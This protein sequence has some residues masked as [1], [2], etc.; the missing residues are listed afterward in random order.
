MSSWE[1]ILELFPPEQQLK[2]I[3]KEEYYIPVYA[4]NTFAANYKDTRCIFALFV[5]SAIWSKGIGSV[6]WFTLD[7]EELLPRKFQFLVHHLDKVEDFDFVL[8]TAH[9]HR[10]QIKWDIR[11]D[12]WKYLNN[13][14]V[15]FQSPSTSEAEETKPSI[16]GGFKKE[17]SDSKGSDDEESNSEKESD[18][19]HTPEDNNTA[20]VDK[21]LQQTEAT[22]T[23]T[24]QKLA[25]RPNTP[26]S[27]GTLIRQTSMLP[28][29]SK[30][31]ISEE[32]LLPTP[33]MSKAKGQ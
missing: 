6:W 15:H 7:N 24:I 21:L 32:S 3:D 19:A 33:P 9:F 26:S 1:T 28:G 25:S 11:S 10:K 18:K 17:E 23:L 14:T 2:L 5:Q 20:K 12:K 22:V 29:S 16:P 27:K 4:T 30:L 8:W 13:W 31:S